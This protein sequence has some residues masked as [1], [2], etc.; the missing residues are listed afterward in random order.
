MGGGAVFFLAIGT[1]AC[2]SEPRIGERRVMAAELAFAPGDVGVENGVHEGHAV[3][4]SV[5]EMH[6]EFDQRLRM[7]S[8]S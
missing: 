7:I 1:K 6:F 8:L 3:F 2:F 5:R 4:H